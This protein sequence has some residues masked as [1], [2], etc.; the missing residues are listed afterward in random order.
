MAI[1]P[2]TNTAEAHPSKVDHDMALSG[3][4]QVWEPQDP[5]DVTEHLPYSPASGAPE[6][7]AEFTQGHKW[8]EVDGKIHPGSG[9]VDI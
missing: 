1:N 3:N 7:I 5:V 2:Q 9:Q 4:Q 8:S 6:H